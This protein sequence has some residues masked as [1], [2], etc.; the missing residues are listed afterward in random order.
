MKDKDY[1]KIIELTYA[2][3]GFIPSN[4]RADELASQCKRG[5]NVSFLEI[6]SRD[7][8][9]HKSYFALLKYIYG[10][11]PKNF[12]KKIPES[13]FYLFLKCLKGDYTVQFEFKNGLK[14]IEYKSI[15]FS[16]MSNEEFKDYIREQLPFIYSEIIASFYSGDM[17]DNVVS[18]IEQRCVFIFSQL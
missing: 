15:S 11:L 14:M 4:D 10:Y 6:T 18:D 1:E 9:L 17:Y 7:L 8:T 3:A 12:K 13:K 2:G 5:Q 16:S